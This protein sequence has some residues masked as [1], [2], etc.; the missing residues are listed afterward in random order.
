MPV[1]DNMAQPIKAWTYTQGGYPS[2]VHQT[3][4]PVPAPEKPLSP[5]QLRVRVKAAALNPIDVQL[6]NIP[7]WPYIP[8]SLVAP[9]KGIGEDFAGVVEQAGSATGFKP[10]DH[11]LGLGPILPGGTLQELITIDLTG[12]AAVVLKPSDWSWEEA[13]ALP[14]V[15]L[16][17]RAMI[18]NVEAYMP[19]G[20]G[21]KVAVLG[22]SSASGMYA[23]HMARQRGW[24]VLASCS[25]PKTEFVKD[26]GAHETVD[27]TTSSVPA[28]VGKF[29]PHAI[30]D[31]VG[32]TECLDLARRYVTIVGD[33]TNRLSLG[34]RSIYLWNPQMVLRSLK[35]ALGLGQSYTCM[36]LGWNRKYLE[37]L[38]QLPRQ[39]IIID[40]TWAFGQ[41]KE[42][43]DRLNSG[44]TKG[45]VV[46]K[47]AE[48]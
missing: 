33:K 32:G 4:I 12:S 3:T 30:I 37:E 31:T 46:V 6:I 39:N 22:G 18:A 10:G 24:T 11:V 41:V 7:L 2:A 16:T 17:A 40:S 26:M 1:R 43:F 36:D 28:T 38:L 19:P 15:W 27:Y 45:K 47:V 34:G 21:G 9:E 44:K 20:G 48:T 14:L 29:A 13:A 42:A 23:V 5:T 25:S 8:S 35:G